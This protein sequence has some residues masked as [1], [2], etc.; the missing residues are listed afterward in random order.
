LVGRRSWWASIDEGRRDSNEE[1]PPGGGR[2]TERLTKWWLR[3][4]HAAQR[5]QAHAQQRPAL[6]LPLAFVARYTA[7][8][9]GG[10][11]QLPLPMAHVLKTWNDL[12]PI[13]D[14]LGET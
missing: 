11:Q 2:P 8:R 7:R 6:G 3:A 13:N 14:R 10:P 5:Y 9:G 1:L 4:E 12:P